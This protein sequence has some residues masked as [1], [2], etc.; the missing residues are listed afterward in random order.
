[1]NL[2]ALLQT[3][4]AALNAAPAPPGQMTG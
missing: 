2:A 1:V 3:M 4:E